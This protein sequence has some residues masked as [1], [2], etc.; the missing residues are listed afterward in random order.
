MSDKKIIAKTMVH[1][2]EYV[3][4]QARYYNDSDI[5]KRL[6]GDVTV[7]IADS[8]HSSFHS[9]N[10]EVTSVGSTMN[11]GS[12]TVLYVMIKNKSNN[13]VLLSLD[14]S[15]Y[16]TS[17]KKNDIFSSEVNSLSSANIKVKTSSGTSN[18]EYIVA[19]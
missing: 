18:I 14:G 7:N 10:K 6:S 4:V 8:Q 11:T 5:G 2:T 17:I 13:D 15:N 3:N 1:P 19:Q 16:T 12:V 9:A